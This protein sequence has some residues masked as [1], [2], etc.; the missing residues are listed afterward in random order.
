[1]L[2]A[3][4]SFFDGSS[5]AKHKVI[6]RLDEARGVLSFDGEALEQPEEWPLAELR[7]LR[8]QPQGG[9]LSFA[10]HIRRRRRNPAPRSASLLP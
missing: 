8:D 9:W 7:L 10:L 5:A 1:M 4:G 6:L 3:E 2:E